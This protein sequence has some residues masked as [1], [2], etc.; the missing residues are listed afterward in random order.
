[1]H[2][3]LAPARNQTQCFQRITALAARASAYFV[4]AAAARELLAA[5]SAAEAAS[6]AAAKQGSSSGSTSKGAAG[7]AALECLLLWLATYSDLFSRPCSVTRKL[8]CWE[9]GSAVPLPPVVRPF[10][11]SKQQLAAAAIDPSLRDAYHAHTAPRDML[12]LQEAALV[13]PPGGTAEPT[14]GA[15]DALEQQLLF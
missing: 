6:T 9:P 8:L 2:L 10:R 7:L 13:P 4:R 15:E 3:A 11:L 14:A 5:G 1:V 12:V